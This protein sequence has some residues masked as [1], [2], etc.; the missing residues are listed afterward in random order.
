M[1]IDEDFDAAIERHS[2]IYAGI[3]S[4]E[5]REAFVDSLRMFLRDNDGLPDNTSEAIIQ[6]IIESSKKHM[7]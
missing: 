3:N 7:N 1:D 2:R 5:G 4:I 6:E